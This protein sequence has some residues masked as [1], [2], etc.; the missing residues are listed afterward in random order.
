MPLVDS[1]A[2]SFFYTFRRI[3]DAVAR[4]SGPAC[5]RRAQVAADVEIPRPYMSP[6][7]EPELASY[8]YLCIP[9]VRAARICDTGHAV[10]SC[11]RLQPAAS[12]RTTCPT[13][14]AQA[15]LNLRA[16][17]LLPSEP[18]T[19]LVVYLL[20]AQFPP[21]RTVS[22]A[23]PRRKLALGRW[24]HCSPPPR[25]LSRSSSSRPALTSLWERRRRVVDP[26]DAQVVD[27]I[28]VCFKSPLIA[29]ARLRVDRVPDRQHTRED[30]PGDP[31]VADR[32]G[33]ELRVVP[34]C[35]AAEQARVARRAP[36]RPLQVLEIGRA[37]DLRDYPLRRRSTTSAFPRS[38][39][40]PAWQLS[41]VDPSV[42]ALC[43]SIPA[44]VAPRS[45][46]KS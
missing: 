43:L 26:S 17:A 39:T 32:F 7:G 30:R 1:Q 12:S 42:R 9:V 3:R 14:S 6:R 8:R 21:L 41:A 23:R 27:D 22:Q 5:A 4:G 28:E 20:P 37:G 16:Q 29:A 33:V 18:I 2:Y 13:R 35:L 15:A 46:R 44:P 36:R 31:R 24:R 25:R 10:R 45:W 38:E 11:S 34:F 40:R 19:Q